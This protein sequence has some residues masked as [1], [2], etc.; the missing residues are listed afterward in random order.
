MGIGSWIGKAA[1]ALG[2]GLLGAASSIG[3][4]FL[5]NELA[6]GR[7]KDQYQY[8]KQL[9]E[10][11]YQWQMEDMRRAGLNPIL[12]YK[13]GAGSAGGVGLS[14]P[15]VPDLGSSARQGARAVSEIA[16]IKAQ[17]INTKAD[18]RLKEEQRL[19]THQQ[20]L[21][22]QLDKMKALEEVSTAKALRKMKELEAIR[23]QKQGDSVL[24]RNIDTLE[25]TGRRMWKGRPR[26]T[27]PTGE[28]IRKRFPP[29]KYRRPSKDPWYTLKKSIQKRFPPPKYR[30]IK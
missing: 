7:T 20:E 11:R 6:K 29:P 18:S 2:G 19:L 21:K 16:Q 4:S 15:S 8:Q 17:T 23:M 13:T 5:E 9:Y 26:Y 25:K 24:G 3:G 14:T 1:G 28:Q 10:N 30:R 27:I 12:S 22:T